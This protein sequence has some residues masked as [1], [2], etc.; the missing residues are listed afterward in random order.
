M[1]LSHFLDG[2]VSKKKMKASLKERFNIMA[3][4]YGWLPTVLRHLWF[5]CRAAWFKLFHG[6]I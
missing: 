4:Y 2:G 3:H 6:W 5:V 1:V